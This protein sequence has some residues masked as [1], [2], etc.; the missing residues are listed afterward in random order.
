MKRKRCTQEQIP[1][2]LRQ[3]ESGTSIAQIV[4]VTAGAVPGRLATPANTAAL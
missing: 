4:P 3:H 2:A 1:F